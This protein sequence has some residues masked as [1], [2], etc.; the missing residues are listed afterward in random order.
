MKRVNGIS[1]IKDN[2]ERKTIGAVSDFQ[3]H[4]I[5]DHDSVDENVSNHK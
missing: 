1:P 3:K 4:D 5:S 2:Q